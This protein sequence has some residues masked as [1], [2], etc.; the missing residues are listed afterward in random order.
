MTDFRTLALTWRPNQFL[1][2]PPGYAANAK[3]H[4]IS[5][6]FAASADDLLAAVKSVALAEPRTTLHGEERAVRRIELIQRSK[7]FGFPDFITVEAVPA[8]A[9]GSALAIYGRAKY[10]IRDFGVNRARIERWLAALGRK[11]PAV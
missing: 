11:I 5:P 2:L 10:G 1:V 7:L 8:A 6:V 3:P 9:G 4:R